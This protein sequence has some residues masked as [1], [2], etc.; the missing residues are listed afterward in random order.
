M[1]TKLKKI[2]Q[3]FIALVQNPWLLNKIIQDD[4]IWKEKMVKKYKLSNGFPVVDFEIICPS[5][6]E[7]IE[8]YASLDG[9][10][11]PSDYA[12]LINL[13]RKINNCHYF[14]IGTW[15]GESVC[16][17]AQFTK[18]CYTLNLPKDTIFN[19]TK[20]KNY[21]NQHGFFS[22]NNPKIN[23][24]EGDSKTFDFDAL[25]KKFDLIFIDGNHT[26]E[27]VKNDTQKV[28]EH[29]LKENTIVVWHD[30]GHSPEKIRPEVA[31]G[32][33]EGVPEIY[34]N[35]LYHVSNTKCAIFINE[36][37]ETHELIYPENPKNIYRLKFE[38]I[39]ISNH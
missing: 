34:H 20:N 12:L 14:E 39:Q 28:F 16:N 29:L 6:N 11:M 21:A 19:L 31:L 25:N 1:L 2:V 30:Y 35:R 5:I 17:V 10:S 23:H 8:I 3:I 18:E 37:F 36:E 4:Q 24:L 13:A 26:F 7:T 33:L 27:Y 22:K 9:V 32:I 38:K 15:R